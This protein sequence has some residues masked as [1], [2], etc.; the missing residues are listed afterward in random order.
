MSD[1]PI[2]QEF[3]TLIQRADSISI[4]AVRSLSFRSPEEFE[5][6][7]GGR[8]FT[9]LVREFVLREWKVKYVQI[10][11]DYNGYHPWG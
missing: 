8:D 9:A 2:I 1:D 3:H 6:L 7:L 4:E 11:Q 5:V 10:Q